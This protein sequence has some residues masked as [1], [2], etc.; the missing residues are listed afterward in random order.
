[1]RF[2]RWLTATF[3][4]KVAQFFVGLGLLGILSMAANISQM[5]GISLKDVFASA[6]VDHA[7]RELV[8]ALVKDMREQRSPVSY[9]PSCEPSIKCMGYAYTNVSIAEVARDG[10]VV[11]DQPIFLGFEPPS[12][13]A[14]TRYV[15]NPS[16]PKP[17]GDVIR[18][19]DNNYFN[20]P[21]NKCGT[22]MT[23]SF[24]IKN[25]LPI[26]LLGRPDI[27][28]IEKS[29]HQPCAPAFKDG[30]SFSAQSKALVAAV[31]RWVKENGL[32]SKILVSASPK[33]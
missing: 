22:S 26:V 3:P 21:E 12:I 33:I 13:L 18:N 20:N 32:A 11:S 4:N 30:K 28:N 15:E 24:A 9:I 8:T 2:F 19:F 31:E 14:F 1:M 23:R 7:Q 10:L 25:D 17:I 6:A 29:F 27:N 16:L 5:T